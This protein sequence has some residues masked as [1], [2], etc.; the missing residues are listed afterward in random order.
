MKPDA[1]DYDMLG[2]AISVL[3]MLVCVVGSAIWSC[4]V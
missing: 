4:W 3:G 1:I 2:L